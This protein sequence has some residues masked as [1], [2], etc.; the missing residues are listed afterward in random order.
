MS[1]MRLTFKRI[2]L[3]TAG[4]IFVITG[5]VGIFLP[6]LP[7]TPFLLLA[8]AC[9]SRSSEK[10]HAW[11]IHHPRIGHF[12]R[13]WEQHRV[14]PKRAKILSSTMMSVMIGYP[15]FVYP[16][17]WWFKAFLVL[18]CVGVSRFIWSC[19][20]Q[21]PQRDSVS[22][23]SSARLSYSKDHTYSKDHMRRVVSTQHSI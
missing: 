17:P 19:P 7:T 5:V 3:I 13:D 8:A 4:W 12:V 16:H 15:V 11:L 14:I 20:H 23:R 18:M 10:L 9:F 2:A 22:A 21:P 1:N 6:L